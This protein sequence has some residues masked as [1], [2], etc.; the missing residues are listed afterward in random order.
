MATTR[1]APLRM[2]SSWRPSGSPPTTSPAGCDC[3]ERSA[4]Y[5]A[6][7]CIASS[8]VGTRT[9]AAIPGVCDCPSFSMMGRRN[10]SVLPVPVW[11]VAMTSLPSSACGIAAACT[12][13]GMENFAAMSRSFKEGDRVSSEKLCILLSCWREGGDTHE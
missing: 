4:L 6:T 7:T 1:R 3:L 11:A 8:R 5:C 12:G 10:A 9:R 2:A 13:V